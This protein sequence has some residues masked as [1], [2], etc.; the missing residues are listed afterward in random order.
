M[1]HSECGL[2]LRS[3][4]EESRSIGKPSESC[5]S[6]VVPD[7]E[8]VKPC[9]MVVDLCRSIMARISS[10]SALTCLCSMTQP[11]SSSNIIRL[12]CNHKA[13][14]KE[15]AQFLLKTSPRSWYSAVM[16]E[17]SGGDKARGDLLTTA[18]G[19]SN[20]RQEEKAGNQEVA[21]LTTIDALA[22]FE[23]SLN[24]HAL[25]RDTRKGENRKTHRNTQG[26]WPGP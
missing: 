22:R 1:E 3:P 14:G 9:F 20:C 18:E 25:G 13:G 2:C 4:H 7:K 19:S 11:K 8:A 23:S 6:A 5:Y 10:W 15:R 21:Q 26:I 12:Q 16:A 17:R 24:L